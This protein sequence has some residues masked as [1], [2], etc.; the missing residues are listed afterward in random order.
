MVNHLYIT[1]IVYILIETLHYTYTG[2][3]DESVS[4]LGS[5]RFQLNGKLNKTANDYTILTKYKLI[6]RS[7]REDLKSMDKNVPYECKK[8]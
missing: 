4:H 6:N 5:P 1:F 2:G 3:G 8:M 7:F